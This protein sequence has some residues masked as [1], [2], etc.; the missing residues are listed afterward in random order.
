MATQEVLNRN[1]HIITQEV[2]KL[3]MSQTSLRELTFDLLLNIPNFTSFPG[4]KDCLKNLS[5]LYCSS[6]IYPEF[7]YQLSQLCCNIQLLN[8]TFVKAISNGLSNLMYRF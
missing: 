1:A 3:L 6:D 8:I 4:A 5:E 7:F 2:L